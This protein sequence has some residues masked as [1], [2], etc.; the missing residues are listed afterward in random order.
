M[1]QRQHD[2]IATAFDGLVKLGTD[3]WVQ[4]FGVV[5]QLLNAHQQGEENVLYPALVR[6]GLKAARRSRQGQQRS[7]GLL[8]GFGALVI[9][10]D[11]T[12]TKS[13]CEI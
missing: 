9:V 2:G 8:A 1:I 4:R 13:A 5:D 10:R 6:V 7:H 12:E 3:G 11:H